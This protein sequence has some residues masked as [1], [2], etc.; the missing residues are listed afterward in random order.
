MPTTLAG[1]APPSVVSEG[2][3]RRVGHMP[4]ADGLGL[5]RDHPSPVRQHAGIGERG[6]QPIGGDVGGVT[7]ATSPKRV[8]W[9]L[10][11]GPRLLP[12]GTGPPSR[13]AQG[14]IARQ[15]GGISKA[16]RRRT[17][18]SETVTPR[19]KGGDV[20]RSPRPRRRPRPLSN[21][22][23]H[24]RGVD[25]A[26]A[27]PRQGRAPADPGVPREASGPVGPTRTSR[28]RPDRPDPPAAR[29]VKAKRGGREADRHTGRAP[30]SIR[31]PTRR[32]SGP[33]HAD[34]RHRRR[35]WATRQ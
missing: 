20:P 5:E 31:A 12:A 16:D 4:R 33:P 6:S 24:A 30:P 15:M 1:P 9:V 27:P 18:S 25:R 34:H 23:P 2:E 32:H 35:R 26:R 7:H 22:A 10:P 19:R 21:K 3:A 13:C 11:W 17:R 28:P 14:H 8:G 29:G